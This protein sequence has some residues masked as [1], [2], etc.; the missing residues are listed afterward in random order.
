VSNDYVGFTQHPAIGGHYSFHEEL[1]RKIAGFFKRDSAIIYTTGYTAN[2][3]SLLSML[4]KSDLAILDMAVHVS[5]Y[6]GCMNTKVRM[7]I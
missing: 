5:V 4:R 2:S 1:E 7:F 3:A 6:E